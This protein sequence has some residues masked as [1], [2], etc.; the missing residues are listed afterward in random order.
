MRAT[1]FPSLHVSART[2]FLFGELVFSSQRLER[3]C[4]G[5]LRE[6]TSADGSLSS[7]HSVT[8]MLLLSAK[9]A[10][11]SPAHTCLLLPTCGCARASWCLSATSQIR[12]KKAHGFCSAPFQ[13]LRR[14]HHGPSSHHSMH[15]SCFLTVTSAS[16]FFYLFE[17]LSL[18]SGIGVPEMCFSLLFLLSL[19]HGK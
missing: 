5:P 6:R 19:C 12:S 3:T 14:W 17:Q 18:F 7:P 1:C 16:C 9:L 4:E 8:P 2:D 11:P 15:S 13:Q 10:Q